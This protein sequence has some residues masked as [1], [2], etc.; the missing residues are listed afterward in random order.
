MDDKPWRDEGY[1]YTFNLGVR[2]IE[3]GPFFPDFT[4]RY[5]LSGLWSVQLELCLCQKIISRSSS[6]S[7]FHR[8]NVFLSSDVSID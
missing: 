8:F 6:C 4:N 3:Y 1:S 2:R 5:L 7:H